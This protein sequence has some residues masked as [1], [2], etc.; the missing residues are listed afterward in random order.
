MDGLPQKSN[1]YF[2]HKPTT[3][4]LVI[5]TKIKKFWH[6]TLILPNFLSVYMRGGR[7]LLF[8]TAE[9]FRRCHTI[10]ASAFENFFRGGAHTHR[11]R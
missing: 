2:L 8:A 1:F 5:P 6:L 9:N 3:L 4:G 7:D 10:L 11:E